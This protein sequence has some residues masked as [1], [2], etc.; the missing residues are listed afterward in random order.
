MA[1]NVH[2]IKCAADPSAAPTEIGQHWINT[3]T[4]EMWFSK[5]TSGVGDWVKLEGDTD[6]KVNVSS[7][8][9]TA[10]FLDTKLTAGTGITLTEQNDGGNENIEIKASGAALNDEKVKVTAN[11]TTEGYLNDKLTAGSSKVTLT[12]VN[13]GGDEDLAVDIVEANIDHDALNNFVANEHIDWTQASAGTIDPTNY[14][15]NDEKVKVSRAK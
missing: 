3:S 12:E 15:D 1:L 6:I 10:G 2:V 7:N 11:D 8:D 5:G 4:G 13:D 14:T 9:S